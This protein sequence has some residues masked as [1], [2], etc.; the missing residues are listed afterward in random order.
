MIEK[1]F[2]KQSLKRVELEDYLKKELEKAGFTK[3]EIV[4]TPL[5]TRIVVNVTRPGLAIGKAGANI[6]QITTTIHERFG[7]EN[8]QLEIKEITVP[9]LDAQ[10]VANKIKSLIESGYSW[11]SVVF[12]IVKQ[13][14]DKNAQGVEIVVSGKLA[15]KSGRKRKQRIASGYMKKVGYQTKFVDYGKASAYPKVGAI[16]IKVRIVKPDT[17]FP[18]K[19]NIPALLDSREAKKAEK[20]IIE[21]KPKEEKKEKEHKEEKKKET[22][23]EKPKEEVKKQVKEEKHKISEKKEKPKEKKEHKEEKKKEVHKEK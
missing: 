19:I 7:I 4:K 14:T 17:V 8:P 16:G 9:E 1:T 18:D 15:G 12:K 3:S 21:E 22:K 20:E 10:A 13:I 6:K 2:L 23:Q 11:R 5:V